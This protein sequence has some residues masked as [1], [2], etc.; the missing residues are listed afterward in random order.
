MVVAVVR[1]APLSQ[2][3][4]PLEPR[5][6][7]V[8]QVRATLALLVSL[9][10]VLGAAAAPASAKQ[11]PVLSNFTLAVPY[12]VLHPDASPRGADDFACKPTAAHPRPVVLVHGTF[13][14]RFN[15]F[16]ALAPALKRQGFC[17]FSLN[18]GAGQLRGLGVYGMRSIRSSADQLA[19]FVDRVRTATGAPQVD[20]V[21]YS[22]GAVVA[23]AYL[24]WS[25]GANPADPAANAVHALVGLS[26]VNHGTK[27]F[28]LTDLMKGFGLTGLVRSQLGAGPLD[29]VVGS[30]LLRELNAGSETVPGVRYTMIA[31]QTDEVSVP[32]RGAHLAAGPGAPGA[33]G[34]PGSVTNLVLQRGCPTD[35]S[36]HFN[37]TYSPRAA[38]LVVRALDPV[39][40]MRVP[41]GIV[42]PFL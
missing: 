6:L 16:A 24:R 26:G 37:I 28:G 12:G 32:Y 31:T 1:R 23:R 11:G 29:L 40:T 15:S 8:P 14:N 34:A 42:L 3:S 41:C 2:L 25:G 33:A 21:G 13:A 27:L 30:S 19:A 20:L 10:P 35:L 39:S 36:D 5:V 9:A 17:V 22:Q 38:A 18:Y 7:R 4:R